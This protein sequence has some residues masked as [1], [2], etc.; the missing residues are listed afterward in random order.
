M[1]SCLRTDSINLLAVFSSKYIDVDLVRGAFFVA[2]GVTD[3]LGCFT[4]LAW[5]FP[6]APA[7]TKVAEAA[8]RVKIEVKPRMMCENARLN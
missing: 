8:R 3:L 6:C 4:A 1:N 7:V 2:T 5:G